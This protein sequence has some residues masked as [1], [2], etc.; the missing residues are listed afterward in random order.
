MEVLMFSLF[1]HSTKLRIIIGMQEYQLL[2]KV[3]FTVSHPIKIYQAYKE[4]G[5]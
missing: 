1:N 2:K 3:N 5:K 4:A